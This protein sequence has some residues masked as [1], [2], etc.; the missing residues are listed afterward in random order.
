MVLYK[1][2]TKTTEVEPMKKSFAFVL[3][4]HGGPRMMTFVIVEGVRSIEAARAKIMERL[5][6]DKFEVASQHEIRNLDRP[7]YTQVGFHECPR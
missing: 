7:T 2:S 5:E 3:R 1:Y 6:S 4:P